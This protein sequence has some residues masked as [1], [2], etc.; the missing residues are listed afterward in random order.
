M[1]D[2]ALSVEHSK[3]T[4]APDSGR[5]KDSQGEERE[6][7]QQRGAKV[8]FHAHDLP[9]IEENGHGIF[10]AVPSR[11]Q[12]IRHALEPERFPS[13]GH[14]VANCRTHRQ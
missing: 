2:V 13:L 5:E 12:A 14:L 8:S 3:L 4:R 7:G 9:W 11:I 6:G 1:P 10:G